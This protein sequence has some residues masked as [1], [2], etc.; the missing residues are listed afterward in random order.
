MS[1]IFHLHLHL[2]II[3]ISYNRNGVLITQ[4]LVATFYYSFHFVIL[5]CVK[6]L[7]CGKLGVGPGNEAITKG[8]VVACACTCIP[9]MHWNSMFLYK[10]LIVS[11]SSSIAMGDMIYV[12]L[13][14]G[15]LDISLTIKEVCHRA[16]TLVA[17]LI[18]VSETKTTRE[19]VSLFLLFS[20]FQ[21]KEKWEETT[22]KLVVLY[23]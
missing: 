13:L 9:D 23:N 7:Y 22:K 10:N 18:L 11:V 17:W 8:R 6:V 15:H 14:C 5:Y 2:H 4:C 19:V 1:I 12:M 20:L 3:A 21:K 16:V